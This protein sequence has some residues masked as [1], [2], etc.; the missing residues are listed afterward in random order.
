MFANE[1]A[2]EVQTGEV[3]GCCMNAHATG[4]SQ[5][6]L[7]DGLRASAPL[8]KFLDK[9]HSRHQAPNNDLVLM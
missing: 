6:P 5:R 9:I 1:T 7:V 3:A 8:L 4:A 2:S